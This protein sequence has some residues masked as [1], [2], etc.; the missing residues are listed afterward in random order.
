VTLL[1]VTQIVRD[2]EVWKPRFDADETTRRRFG[3]QC[4]RLYR[5]PDDGNDIA[6]AI[7]MPSVDAARRLLLDAKA[8]EVFIG[9]ALGEP[10]IRVRD[11]IEAVEYVAVSPAFRTYVNSDGC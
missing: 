8:R 6:I 4:H 9:G 10:A 1:M 3:A 5:D 7:D 2:F 11:H